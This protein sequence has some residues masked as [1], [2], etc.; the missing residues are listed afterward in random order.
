MH[1]YAW[2]WYNSSRQSRLFELYLKGRI[3]VN[4]WMLRII[5][6]QQIEWEAG[7][8][9][10]LQFVDDDLQHWQRGQ[11]G[12]SWMNIKMNK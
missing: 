12:Q 3:Y 7:K 9:G 1:I 8:S 5:C 10:S 11:R 2:L 6:K 4:F